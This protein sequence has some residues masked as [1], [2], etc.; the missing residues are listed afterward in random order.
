MLFLYCR[1]ALKLLALLA[2]LLQFE[3]FAS[4]LNCYYERFCSCFPDLDESF[5]SAGSIFEFTPTR[6]SYEANPPF[7]PGIMQ[8]T[9][10][11]IEVNARVLRS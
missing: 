2:C 3:L 9:V 8:A 7:A 1:P 6:G 5:G 11:H 10:S 4:P